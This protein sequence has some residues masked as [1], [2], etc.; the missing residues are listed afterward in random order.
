[1]LSAGKSKH[2]L[3][4]YRL[5]QARSYAR[6]FS[7]TVARIEFMY[8]LSVEKIVDTVIAESF[9]TGNIKELD[10]DWEEFKQYIKQREDMRELD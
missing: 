10:R 6:S 2:G 1:M 3:N 8:Q 7:E 4:Q 5:N 9:I